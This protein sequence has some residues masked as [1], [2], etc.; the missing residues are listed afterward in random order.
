MKTVCS[1]AVRLRLTADNCSFKLGDNPLLPAL[2]EKVKA[3]NMKILLDFVKT[4]QY[5]L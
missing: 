1:C 4:E 5:R 2:E 3:G